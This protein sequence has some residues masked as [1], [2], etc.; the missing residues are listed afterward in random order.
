MFNV[1]VNQ[2]TLA[3]AIDSVNVL[4]DECKIRY[5]E[6][7]LVIRA[8]DPANVGMVDI[9]LAKPAFESFD[10]NEG[11]IGVN[12]NRLSDIISMGDSDSLVEFDLDEETRKL[13]IYIDNMSY[14]LAL[15]NPDSIRQEP[16]IPSLDLPVEAIIEGSEIHRAIEAADMVSDHISLGFNEEKDEFTVSA[17]GDTDDVIYSIDN[18]KMID[19]TPGNANSLFSIDYLK[20]IKRGIPKNSEVTVNVGTEFPAM[21]HLGLEEGLLDVT[22][23][24]APRI[25]SD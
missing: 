22:Y 21:F 16:D 8:V 7:G 9:S 10:T 13:H 6:D 20:D 18:E 4:V 14:T 1:I 11:I 17:E 25:N 24:L 2:S 5:N 15:I 23:V 3:K 19:F 12:L